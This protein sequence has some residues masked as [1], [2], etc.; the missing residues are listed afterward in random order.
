MIFAQ[1]FSTNCPQI[2]RDRSAN[3]T[4]HIR[5]GTRAAW[6]TD[7]MTKKA[8]AL[9]KTNK[10]TD[11][12]TIPQLHIWNVWLAALHAIQGLIV[13][14]L[15]ATKVF[16][17]QTNYL[18][19]DLI[20]SELQGKPVLGYASS[21][22]FDINLAYLVAAFFFMSAIA[23]AVV[24]TIL[25]KRYEADLKQGRNTVRWYE[26]ALS[27]STMMVAIAVLSGIASISALIM[28]FVLTLLMNAMGLIME[29]VN[30]G[31]ARVTW[32]PYGI[33][34]VAGIVPW[35]VVAIYM[36]GAIQHGNGIPAF[37]YWI[38]ATM[39][40][41]FGSFAVNMYLQYKKVGKWKEYLYGERMYMIL[42]LVAKTALAWQ[43]FAGTLRP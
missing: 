38:Y 19:P 3:C 33:G 20:A 42:S 28:I 35:V 32:L 21:H 14:L 29:F 7:S 6:Y 11:I 26:Y 27:A 30:Q 37:V 8:V 12:I 25:R 23:H 2:Y 9:E 13:L 10:T 24:A 22:L 43:V 39:F 40:V 1:F 41:L 15:S 4:T 17:V 16:P 36:A 18:T 34:C 31:R 5:R